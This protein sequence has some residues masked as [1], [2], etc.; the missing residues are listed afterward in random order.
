MYDHMYDRLSMRDVLFLIQ[1]YQEVKLRRENNMSISENKPIHNKAEQQACSPTLEW[2]DPPGLYS[3][4]PDKE[5]LQSQA[6]KESKC[7]KNKRRNHAFAKDHL[8]F[9]NSKESEDCADLK[10]TKNY[11]QD[12]NIVSK[13]IL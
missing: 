6:E 10:T 11:T 4:L 5:S 3:C 2:S 8:T 13:F 7:V 9:Q 1:L 12:L